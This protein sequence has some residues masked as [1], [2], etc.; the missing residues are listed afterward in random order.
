MKKAATPIRKI[1][2]VTVARSDYGIYRPLLRRLEAAPDISLQLIV[3]GMHLAPE[4]GDTRTEILADGFTPA[5]E[6]DFSLAGD[7]PGSLARA[8][9]LGTIGFAQALETLQPDVLVVLGD[10]IEMHA[11]AVAAQP[12]LIPVAH[13]AG[14]ALTGGAIDD[15]LRHSMTKL[16]SLHFPEIEINARASGRWVNRPTGST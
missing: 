7:R 12:F 3:A 9:G 2:V 8:M 16:S 4:F 13:I 1:A 11:A 15:S 6:V 14:G 5:A 10:R